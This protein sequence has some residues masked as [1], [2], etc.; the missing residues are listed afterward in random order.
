VLY[1]ILTE[2]GMP[3]KLVGIM[4]MCLK[5]AYSQVRMGKILIHYLFRMV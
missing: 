4:K 5:E 2:F 1:N 3:M